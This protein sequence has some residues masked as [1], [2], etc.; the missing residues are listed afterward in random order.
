MHENNGGGDSLL[1]TAAPTKYMTTRV[2]PEFLKYSDQKQ[3]DVIHVAPDFNK[4]K[5]IAP[6][7]VSEISL[8]Q[9]L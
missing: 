4:Y 1:K 8:L 9:T 3:I 2:A 5:I 7:E 6:T